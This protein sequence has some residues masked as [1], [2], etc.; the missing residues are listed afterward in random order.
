LGF[1]ASDANFYRYVGNQPTDAS[2]PDGLQDSM[3]N[4][5]PRYAKTP[6]PT[7]KGDFRLER[8]R[9]ANPNKTI[10]KEAGPQPDVPVGH[11]G[12]A[13]YGQ[14]KGPSGTFQGGWIKGERS[15]LTSMEIT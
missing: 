15:T 10:R 1:A 5:V 9:D 12:P 3:Y 6:I 14:F 7:P 13:N 8:N 11:E 4:K 2:D